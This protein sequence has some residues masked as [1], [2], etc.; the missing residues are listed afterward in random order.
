MGKDLG[1]PKYARHLQTKAQRQLPGFC[2]RSIPFVRISHLQENTDPWNQ[3][4]S[5]SEMD[6]LTGI[7]DKN[8]SSRRC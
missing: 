5:L 1:L 8:W 3:R 6:L 4:R 2:G 7:Q